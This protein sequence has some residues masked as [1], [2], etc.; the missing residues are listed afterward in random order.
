METLVLFAKAPVLG[1]VK[2]RLAKER[3][4]EEALLLYTAF[5]VDVADQCAAWRA[6][7]VA[8]DQNRRLCLYASPDADDPVLAEVARRSGAR[9][10]RQADG[11][12]GMR[13]RACFDAEFQRGAR[14]VCVIG[15]DSPTLPLHLIDEAF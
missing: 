8:V 5:L 7:K 14:S 4:A 1:T 13:L 10:E 9:T 11:D 12:L 3:G 2:T 15:S 6:E